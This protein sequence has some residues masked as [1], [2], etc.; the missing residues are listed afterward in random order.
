[1]PPIFLHVKKPFPK[2]RYFLVRT[3]YM[4]L[5]PDCQ[6]SITLC[7]TIEAIRACSPPLHFKGSRTFI[8]K[9]SMEA[10]QKPL[11]I[12]DIEVEGMRIH[13]LFISHVSVCYSPSLLYSPAHFTL[14]VKCQM[15]NVK[16]HPI[17]LFF[18]F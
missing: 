12:L 7:Q 11:P 17:L 14:L 15:S 1:M 18:P 10:M 16:S 5:G 6:L 4:V 13:T 8:S 3:Y 9:S 2:F